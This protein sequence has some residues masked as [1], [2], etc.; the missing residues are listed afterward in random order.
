MSSHKVGSAAW[1]ERVCSR[2]SACA[3]QENTQSYIEVTGYETAK[4]VTLLFDMSR[5]LYAART[6]L[7]VPCLFWFIVRLPFGSPAMLATLCM[8]CASV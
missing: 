3:S 1:L 4:M 8:L 5:S 7:R 6:N 2:G